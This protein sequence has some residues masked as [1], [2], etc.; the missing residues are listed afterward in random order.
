P[1]CHFL[2]Q[3]ANHHTQF[4]PSRFAYQVDAVGTDF[5]TSLQP[6]E[7]LEYVFQRHL[8]KLLLFEFGGITSAVAK[9]GK[10]QHR[11]AG[12]REITRGSLIGIAALRTAKH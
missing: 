8:A 12:P 6:I 11:I 10:R 2:T 1:P 4:A 3:E 5:W 7:R 9:I